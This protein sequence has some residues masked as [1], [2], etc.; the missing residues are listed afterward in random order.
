MLGLFISGDPNLIGV[1]C[2]LV[3]RRTHSSEIFTK[4]FLKLVFDESVTSAY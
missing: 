3:N 2:C 4:T 1:R